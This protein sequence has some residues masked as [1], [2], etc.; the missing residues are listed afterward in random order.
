MSSSPLKKIGIAAA[1]FAAVWL[2]SRYL[3]PIALP[4]LLAL[5][6]ALA[7]EPLVNVLHRRLHLP[8]ALASGIGVVISLLVAVLFVLTLGALLLR[9]LRSLAGALPNLGETALAGLRS[10]EDFLLRLASK[11]PDTVSPILTNRVQGA[12]SNGT[13]VI[14]QVLSRVFSLASGILTRI[15]DSAFG[16]GTWILASFMTST[17]LPQIRLLL[18]NKLPQSWRERYLPAFRR[19]K[20]NLSGWLFAQLKLTSITFLILCAGFLLL[21]IT[22]APLW[23]LLICFVDAL[24][25]LGTGTVLIPWSLVCF[26][27]GD[28]VRALGLL[29]TY[30]A[31]ALLRSVLE[32]RLV[33]K[34]L[35]LDPLV[36]L[37]AMY[38]GYRLWGILGMICSPLLAVTVTQ[39]LALPKEGK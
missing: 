8:R 32:P 16:F 10:L 30:T 38:A 2:F 18:K 27:Q 12:F 11:A 4:F 28:A 35:G 9:Q 14:N 3:L 15:P 23:A 13:E 5:L 24:P 39:M 17:K 20:Q 1:V 22:Y 34:Q 31:A 21:R 19:L 29:G 6:L 36:T 26:L 33:G 37:F 25:I 7:A